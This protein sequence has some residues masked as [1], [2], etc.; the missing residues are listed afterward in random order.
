[1]LAVLSLIERLGLELSKLAPFLPDF[2]YRPYILVA[3]LV[4]MSVGLAVFLWLFLAARGQEESGSLQVRAE[5]SARSG[6][7]GPAK[8]LFVRAG[9]YGSA[10]RMAL[11]LGS[12]EEAAG[13]AERAGD[14]STAGQLLNSLGKHEAAARAFDLAKRPIEAGE[15][16]RKLGKFELA[17]ARFVEAKD[18]RRTE[19]L[20][21]TLQRW[22]EAGELLSKEHA[23]LAVDEATS[24][25]SRLA[26][27]IQDLA[28]RAG[29]H[30]SMAKEYDRSAE[31][32]LRAGRLA[33]AAS[34]FEAKGDFLR[35]ADLFQQADERE[36][37]AEMYVTAGKFELAAEILTDLGKTEEVT[38]LLEKAG[39]GDEAQIHRARMSLA[40]GRPTQAAEY[41]FQAGQFQEA[42]ELFFENGEHAKA[43]EALNAIGR[44]QEAGD[45]YAAADKFDLA[46]VAYVQAASSA[47][48]AECFEKAGAT[49]AAISQYEA[50]ERYFDS[51]RLAMEAQDSDR[52]IRFFQRVPATDPQSWQAEQALAL[53]FRQKGLF[54]LSEERFGRFRERAPL[55][56]ESLEG[57]YEYATFLEDRGR[58]DEA[59]DLYGQILAFDFHFRDVLARK[60]ALDE[61][62]K[63]VT[64]PEVSIVEDS[65]GVEPSR[66]TPLGAGFVFKE[67][68][69]LMAQ[70]G[71]GAAG[72]VYQAQDRK[73]QRDVAL[74]L[75]PPFAQRGEESHRSFMQEAQVAARLSHPH[76]V[77][78]FDFG[79]D[80]DYLFLVM[81]L[82]RGSSVRELI[83]E[84]SPLPLP[85]VKTL[86][87]QISDALTYAHEAKVVHR[88][89]KSA[90][91]LLT[92]AGEIK[93]ADFGLARLL[94]GADITATQTVGSPYY[95]APEQISGDRYDHRIDLYAVGVVLFELVTGHLPFEEGEVTYHHLHTPPRRP[96]SLRP[97][98]PS[99]WDEV[100]LKLLAKSPAER[101][102][103]TELL[104]AD[105]EKLTV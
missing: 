102:S 11:K 64:N 43:G 45:A 85:Q 6:K 88:D 19:E 94:R 15:I 73:L 48:A 82:I 29:R 31:S 83:K 1:M 35:A 89:I 67:R 3:C 57:Y 52:A 95:M 96:S 103:T 42:A 14:F 16:W 97:D 37:A 51:A 46:A 79:K 28:E 2:P 25:D 72:V 105:L 20:L 61:G 23:R 70:I 93:V 62:R 90:N 24:T 86:A 91:L 92:E 39:R 63:E 33:K 10:A 100:V 17:L 58:R 32:Y 26:D 7:Y 75:L 38:Q 41:L 30:F 65:E 55:G 34:S 12:V 13:L 5:K 98:L 27:R 59:R 53:L 50:A 74:K 9:N 4:S 69:E 21:V 77:A 81:E 54:E 76:I 101:Y 87:L 60:Q 56:L 78:V 104:V 80:H 71:S 66:M 49:D 22:Q 68:Y 18:L 40:E 99:G 47:Q 44:Y 8:E 36:K 84:K